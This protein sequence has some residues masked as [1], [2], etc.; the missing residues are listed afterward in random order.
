MAVI[1]VDQVMN[2]VPY[3]MKIDFEH[4]WLDYDSEADVLYISFKKP[5]QANDS[6]LTKEDI[7]LRYRDEEDTKWRNAQ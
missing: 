2:L 1:S 5:Q 6:E 4:L 3:L 7:I